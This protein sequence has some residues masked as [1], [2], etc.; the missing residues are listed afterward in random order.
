MDDADS[1]V[2]GLLL[3]SCVSVSRIVAKLLGC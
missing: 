3:F 2:L 1:I